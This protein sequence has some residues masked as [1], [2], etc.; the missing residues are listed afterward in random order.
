MYDTY[1]VRTRTVK[2]FQ[3]LCFHFCV[4]YI[5]GTHAYSKGITIFMFY[6]CVR[7]IRGTHAYSKGLQYLCFHF[8]VRYIRGVCFYTAVYMLAADGAVYD[9]P[10]RKSMVMR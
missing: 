6:F 10:K 2:G 9:T 8:C 5:R 1:E 4:R 7:Y 3:Y